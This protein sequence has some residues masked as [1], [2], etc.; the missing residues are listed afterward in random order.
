MIG[1]L[2]SEIWLRK[3]VFGNFNCF[4]S[5]LFLGDFTSVILLSLTKETR[6]S[7]RVKKPAKI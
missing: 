4:F 2:A 1:N 6:M 3:F 7:S 5:D